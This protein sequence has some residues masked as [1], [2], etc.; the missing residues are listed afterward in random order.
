ML[1][2]VIFRR[3]HKLATLFK[4]TEQQAKVGAQLNPHAN[5]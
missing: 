2:Q 5:H 3:Q 4:S 1:P